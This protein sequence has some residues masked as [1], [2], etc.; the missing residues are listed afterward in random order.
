MKKHNNCLVT[1]IPLYCLCPTGA[2]QQ[3]GS[4]PGLGQQPQRVQLPPAAHTDSRSEHRMAG[5]LQPTGLN[6]WSNISSV[7]PGQTQDLVQRG[8]DWSR[9]TWEQMKRIIQHFFTLM[10]FVSQNRWMWIDREGF[11]Y[12]NWYSQSSSSSFPCIHLRTSSKSTCLARS[13][14]IYFYQFSHVIEK[15][16]ITWRKHSYNFG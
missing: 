9:W 5:R 2:L 15:G 3:P 14:L 13:T 12:T 4:P 11:Y 1:K 16:N 6:L 7:S 8:L 10:L